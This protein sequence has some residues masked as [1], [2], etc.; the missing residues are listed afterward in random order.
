MSD[1]SLPTED[2]LDDLSLGHRAQIG[3]VEEA[4]FGRPAEAIEI[5]RFTVRE[6]VGRGAFGV[7]Y[8]ATDPELGRDA[9]V[10]VLSAGSPRAQ[11]KL[12][13]EARLMATVTHPNVATVYEVGTFEHDGETRGFVAMEF[14]VGATLRTVLHRTDLN[15]AAVLDLLVQAGRGLAAAHKAG[16]VHRDFKPDN[17]LVGDDGRVRVVDF[18][19]AS[20]DPHA[21]PTGAAAEDSDE[22]PVDVATRTRGLAG[23]PAYMAPELFDGEPG[24]AHSDQFSFCVTAYEALYGQRPFEGG[25]LMALTANVSA[26]RLAEAPRSSRVSP[27]LR[28]ILVR[29]L[30]RNPA[31]R[32]PSMDDLLADLE[33]ETLKWSLR[34]RIVIVG[35]A[36]GVLGVLAGALLRDQSLTPVPPCLVDVDAL[37]ATW[38]ADRKDTLADVFASEGGELGPQTWSRASSRLD[39]YVERWRSGA[40]ASCERRSD[41]EDATHLRALEAACLERAGARLEALLGELE[42]VDAEL[43]AAAIRSVRALPDP[44]RCLDSAALLAAEPEEGDRARVAEIREALDQASIDS[45]LGR[46]D[47]ARA[48]LDQAVAAADELDFGPLVAESKTRLAQLELKTGHY[49]NS[50]TL[51]RQAFD[52]A[53][54]GPDPELGVA[55]TIVL[56]QAGV[57]DPHLLEESLAWLK[58]GGSLLDRVDGAPRLRSGLAMA[59][60]SLLITAADADA[61]DA[62]EQA[63]ATLRAEDPDHPDLAVA[64][65]NWGTWLLRRGQPSEAIAKYE[66]ALA[67]AERSLGADH[68]D[69]AQWL[70]G[71]GSAAMTVGEL[72]AADGYLQRSLALHRQTVGDG[73][74]NTIRTRMYLG[75][76]AHSRKVFADGVAQFELALAAADD[77]LGAEHPIVAEICLRFA[78]TLSLV[79]D[80]DRAQEI[81]ERARGIYEKMLPEDDPRLGPVYGVAMVTAVRAGRTTDAIV[82]G[83]R[84]LAVT[85]ASGD[86]DP[87]RVNILHELGRILLDAD[88]RSEGIELLDRAAAALADG[89]EDPRR[90]A[91]VQLDLA[92]A[93]WPDDR[94][95]ARR[96]AA[97]ARKRLPADAPAKERAEIDG[98]IREHAGSAAT[99]QPDE[100]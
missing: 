35:G 64:L 33:R 26:G 78:D 89:I 84:G 65:G 54:S 83:R 34:R 86:V 79:G 68:P 3:R 9:A 69:V 63:V 66:H 95:A 61:T 12:L 94:D 58:T 22:L 36:A 71:L 93:R 43:V 76:L 70:L 47:T 96:H 100:P 45:T 24:T 11:D 91:L 73:H 2:G 48:S 99:V 7:V 51:A 88:Q 4:L 40:T 53:V 62:L 17:A 98:W 20:S 19:L 37:D 5:G 25:T 27:R 39:T 57:A 80:H 1:R 52:R 56:A 32:Y 72:D 13:R 28:R 29:G 46:Y 92:R 90:R 42:A 77:S 15:P 67:A 82:H 14:V 97:E 10:K 74:P 6:V 49:P 55:A 50:R 8:A 44:A 16:V 21:E 75:V 38:T 41:T 59:R 85:T 30:E 23:T 60:A 81:A 31:D 87:L 18:G